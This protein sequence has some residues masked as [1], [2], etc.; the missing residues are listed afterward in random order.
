MEVRQP[1]RAGQG[2][3][4]HADHQTNQRLALMVGAPWANE[5]LV[6]SL[7]K[8]RRGHHD[9]G[10][11]SHLAVLSLSFDVIPVALAVR[12]GDDT[13]VLLLLPVH[14]QVGFVHAVDVAFQDR[15]LVSILVLAVRWFEILILL[16]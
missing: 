7:S 10:D 5:L 13:L 1:D 11:E 16:V 3:R 12:P 15:I 4:I 14:R 6:S 2:A 8:N 9:N